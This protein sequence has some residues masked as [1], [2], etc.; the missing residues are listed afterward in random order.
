MQ[1]IVFLALELRQDLTGEN[2]DLMVLAGDEL[3]ATASLAELER[4]IHGDPD[5]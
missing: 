2:R 1:R 4:W 3:I 5:T